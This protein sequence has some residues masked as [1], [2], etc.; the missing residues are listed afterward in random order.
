MD[1]SEREL[2]ACW[3]PVCGFGEGESE[4]D[5]RFCVY[6]HEVEGFNFHFRSRGRFDTPWYFH[7]SLLRRRRPVAN[8]G[9]LALEVIEGGKVVAVDDFYFLRG[10]SL[11]E[12]LYGLDGFLE[13]G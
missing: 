1:L 13:L 8:D 6:P 12:N 2:E 3:C 4:F 9:V 11:G 10:A 7:L 5:V